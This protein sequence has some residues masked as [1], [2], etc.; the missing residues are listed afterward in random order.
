[1]IPSTIVIPAPFEQEQLQTGYDVVSEYRRRYEEEHADERWFEDTSRFE[2]R[3]DWR[4]NPDFW[5]LQGVR[6]NP[7]V[8]WRVVGLL[9]WAGQFSF[10][11][12]FLAVWWFL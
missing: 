7:N 1:M 6:D 4:E 5:S 11:L 9:W 10:S 3:P 2:H 12:G 8:T